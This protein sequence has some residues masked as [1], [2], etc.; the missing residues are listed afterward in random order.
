MDLHDVVGREEAVADAP[1]EG[2]GEHRIAERRDVGH[3][4][5]V[6]IDEIRCKGRP[7]AETP[8]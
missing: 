7:S 1:L 5:P 4:I 6:L 8:A 2:I 3:V